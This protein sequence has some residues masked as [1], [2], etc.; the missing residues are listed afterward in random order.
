MKFLKKDVDIHGYARVK[1]TFDGRKD[2]RLVSLHRLVANAFIPNPY[3]KPDVNH[4]DG[5]KSN[6]DVSNLEWC[7]KTENIRHAIDTGLKK[8]VYGEKHGM[9]KIT[10]QQAKCICKLLESGIYTIKEISKIL[11]VSYDC[12]EHI[13]KKNSWV[14]I[15]N[16]YNIDNYR[17]KKSYSKDEYITVF[18]LFQEN[19]MSIYDISD[20]SE[21][22]GYTVFRIY[23]HKSNSDIVNELYDIY[24]ITKYTTS[25]KFYSKTIS[26]D[27]IEYALKLIDDGYKFKYIERIISKRFN[28]NELFIHHNLKHEIDNYNKK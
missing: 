8:P 2:H 12:I 13:V 24:D 10:E 26:V 27:M 22:D 15:S 18:K 19:I 9:S 5:N 14:R 23:L 1:I 7:T 6:N 25:D 28:I 3:N 21:M 20:K 4:K 16:D 17:H 11:D